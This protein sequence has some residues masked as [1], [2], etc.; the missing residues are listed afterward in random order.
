MSLVSYS[1][2]IYLHVLKIHLHAY[3]T[4]NWLALGIR[5][6]KLNF[7]GEGWRFLQFLHENINA[8]FSKF[9]ST[10]RWKL[11]EN[12]FERKSTNYLLNVQLKKL[13]FGAPCMWHPR[14]IPIARLMLLFM[15][16]NV[17]RKKEP[18]SSQST[19]PDI[20]LPC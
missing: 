18:V 4:L 12:V 7:C 3:I 15:P 20:A 2:I 5:V 14:V 17:R 19:N 16:K 13:T 9:E 1:I 11:L 8:T 10:R 6:G